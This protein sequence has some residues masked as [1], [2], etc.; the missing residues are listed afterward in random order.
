[1][2]AAPTS[3]MVP[4]STATLE[5]YAA[6][7]VVI[8]FATLIAGAILVL[9]HLVGPKR[10]G[11]V[12]DES[13]ESGMPPIADARRRFHVRFYMVAVLFLLFDVE[14]VLL[15]PWAPVFHRAAARGEMVELAGGASAGTA[16][17][18]GAMGLFLALLLVGLIYEW[19]K[20]VFRWD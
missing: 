5:P 19:R 2:H 18:L 3:T 13:Y 12:K 14:V 15:W 11:P 7:L 4:V 6:V 1:M 17:L 8:A 9:S 20:G 10:R 16:Y